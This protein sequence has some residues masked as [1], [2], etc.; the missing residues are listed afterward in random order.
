MEHNTDIIDSFDGMIKGIEMLRLNAMKNKYQI[1]VDLGI[2][3]PK[4]VVLRTDNPKSDFWL[5]KYLNE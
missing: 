5:R 1:S 4:K 3:T 2:D